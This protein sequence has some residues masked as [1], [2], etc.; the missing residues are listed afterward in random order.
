MEKPVAKMIKLFSFHKVCDY[1]IEQ[2]NITD[3]DDWRIALIED[4]ISEECCY[5]LE[6]D[7][8][9]LDNNSGCRSVLTNGLIKYFDVSPQ[10]TIILEN[11]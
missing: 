2:E 11:S 9:E 4:L 8:G 10:E 3:G 6:Y 1:I 7:L 5:V